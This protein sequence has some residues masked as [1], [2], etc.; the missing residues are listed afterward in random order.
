MVVILSG[1]LIVPARRMPGK[2]PV[3]NQTTDGADGFGRS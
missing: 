2:W 3:Q 1:E